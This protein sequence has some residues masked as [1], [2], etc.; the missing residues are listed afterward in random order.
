M[1]VRPVI[2]SFQMLRQG[3]HL[4]FR[5]P[6]IPSKSQASLA[7]ASITYHAKKISSRQIKILMLKMVKIET[8]LKN[9]DYFMTLE[10]RIVINNKILRNNSHMKI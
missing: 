3:D 4:R 6:G 7:S 8:L 10:Y 2:A 5:E 1:V 9:T